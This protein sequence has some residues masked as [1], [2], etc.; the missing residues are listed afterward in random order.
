V[1]RGLV[2]LEETARAEDEARVEA[3]RGALRARG[4]AFA[5]VYGDVSRSDDI[6]YL[7]NLCIYWNEGVLAVPA[8]GEP[9]LLSKLSKRVHP[10]MR[11]SSTLTDL[12]SGRSIGKLVEAFAGEQRSEGP[13]KIGIVDEAWWPAPLVAELRAAL[14][15]AEL[16]SLPD[17]V[18]D[19]RAQP[20]DAEVAL[21]ERAGA[22]LGDAVDAAVALHDATPGERV[23]LVERTARGA[24]FL[25]VLAWAEGS[26]GGGVAIDVIGQLRHVWVRAA[27]TVGGPH[28]EASAAA[29][30]AV[31]ELLAGGV[32]P[33][34]LASAASAAAAGHG[35]STEA[36]TVRCIPVADL[37]TRGGH[38]ALADPDAPLPAGS[39]VA[40][41]IEIDPAGPDDVRAIA[42]DTWLL[43]EGSARK[44]TKGGV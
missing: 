9:A 32:R 18:R 6:N 22:T 39:A 33:L 41:A 36:L 15:D 28:A 14:P 12:R 25:D 2:V 16:V 24:E 35:V 17:L 37:A 38:R 23:A 3:L 27:R 11:T 7:T 44:L 26:D 20:S 19:L 5:L 8:D 30:A 31:G 29:G 4:I 10:W 1:K 13:V 43:G 34:A 42:C 40:V 21:L